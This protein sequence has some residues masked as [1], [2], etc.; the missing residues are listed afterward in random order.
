MKLSVPGLK[1]TRYAGGKEV[2]GKEVLHL[3]DSNIISIR[4][5]NQGRDYVA[6]A[7]GAS[8]GVL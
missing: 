3:R 4:S 7:A 8:G 6:A 1:S 5:S 2:T